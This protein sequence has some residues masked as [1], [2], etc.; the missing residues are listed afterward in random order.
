MDWQPKRK[1]CATA[2]R[3]NGSKSAEEDI[4]RHDGYF[5][6]NYSP[7]GEVARRRV[8]SHV[9][10][11]DWSI[12][13]DECEALISLPSVNLVTITVT[14]SG[15]YTD[16]DGQLNLEDPTIKAEVSGDSSESVYAYLRNCLARRVA[17]T[18]APF[19]P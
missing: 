12:N 2:Y 18:G 13:S 14:E 11:S 5:L 4:Q 7:D 15:Y 19:A 16:P 10:F 8:R 9:Q 1:T 17:S 3:E 6:K